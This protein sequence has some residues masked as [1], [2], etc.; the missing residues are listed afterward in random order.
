MIASLQHAKPILAAALEAGFRESG[1]QSL[2]ALDDPGRFP[3]VAIRTAGLGL[4]SV[5]GYASD[6][7]DEESS[8]FCSLVDRGYLELLLALANERFKANS[9]RTKR[10]QDNLARLVK[11]MHGAKEQLW[12]DKAVRA[13]RKRAEGLQQQAV[14]QQEKSRRKETGPDFQS[15]V[16]ADSDFLNFLDGNI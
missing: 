8:H 1:V 9:D 7:Q 12:E 5:I 13:E 10:L 2:K 16:A 3:M 11:D 15:E 4:S 6:V 14:R